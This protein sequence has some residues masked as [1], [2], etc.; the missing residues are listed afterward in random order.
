MIYKFLSFTDRGVGKYTV[1]LC[2]P[3]EK[4]NPPGNPTKN[5]DSLK[6]QHYQEI[7]ETSHELCEAVSHLHHS[8]SM[9]LRIAIHRDAGAIVGQGGK[10][11]EKGTCADYDVIMTS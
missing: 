7:R 1:E 11:L 5:R 9:Q 6:T 2:Q 10:S 8:Y 4:E 3:N